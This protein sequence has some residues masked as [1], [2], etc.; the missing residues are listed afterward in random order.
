MLLIFSSPG[1]SNIPI[2]AMLEEKL[3]CPVIIENGA[4][5]AAVAEYFYGLGKDFENIAYFNCGVGI[6]T[7]TISS[8]NLIRTMNDEEDA[9]GHMIVNMMVKSVDVEIMGV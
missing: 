2:K 1:W 5:S 8:G 9:F 7:G 6:R 4:N 3:K